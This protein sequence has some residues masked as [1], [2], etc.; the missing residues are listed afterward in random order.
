MH[1]ARDCNDLSVVISTR[2]PRHLNT[3]L[4]KIARKKMR[5]RAEL[6]R[7][8]ILNTLTSTGEIITLSDFD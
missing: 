2:I 4:D 6:V 5:T 3:V 1:V 8:I 7:S